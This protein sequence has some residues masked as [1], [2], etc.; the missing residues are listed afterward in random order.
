MI[1]TLGLAV[2]FFWM[3]REIKSCLFWTYL[4][5]LK[6]YHI[7]RFRAHFS[8]W[9]GRKLLTNP[10]SYLKLLILLCLLSLI[11]PS[12]YVLPF[13]GF[14]DAY[15]AY[16]LLALPLAF[17]IYVAEGLSAMISM[18]RKRMKGPKLTSKTAS[19]LT[20]IFIPLAAALIIFG[21]LFVDDLVYP[22]PWA[23]LDLLPFAFIIIVFDLLTPLLTSL[24]ILIL[25]PVTVLL[26][27]RM[28]RR[29]MK[30]REGLEKLLTIGV[31]GSYGKTSVK[32][33]LKTIL[34]KDFKVVST[35]KNHNSEVG[36]SE[37]IIKDVTED[38]EVFICE[39]GAYNR[40]A[41][42]L[43]CE[44]AKPK[45]GV[46]TGINNQHLATFGSQK[47][48]IRG[49]FE[50]IDALP[51]EG[52]AV[53]NW[54]N[55]FIRDNFNSKVNSLKYS[56]YNKE[57]IWTE[58]IKGDKEK[59][60][61]RAVT[62]TG[63][64]HPFEASLMGVHNVPNLLA[65]IAV[66]KKLGM[67]FPSIAERVKEIKPEQSGMKVLKSKDGYNVIDATYSS[68]SNGLS[69][70]LE[71]LKNWEGRKI[72]IMPC[73]IELGRDAKD[74]HY[75][76][77]RKIGEVCDMAV[78]TSRDYFKQIKKGALETGMKEENIVFMDDY[79]KIYNKIIYCIRD[80][81]VVFLE[82]R[83]PARLTDKLINND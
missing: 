72:L 73:L 2:L 54:D 53:L 6:N 9:N 34:S 52:L 42:R 23:I 21:R 45:I 71:Y 65:A 13:E 29:A 79:Q 20:V 15:G 25:Q 77:G 76:M 22:N 56:A 39:M 67:D 68:N 18:M 82:S 60:S 12:E 81:D 7:G 8:T 40:G 46:L 24:I 10:L 11:V 57:D 31:T 48:I 1:A 38:D 14:F 32:E 75:K 37:C 44:I 5:Q 49:K 27:G 17:L 63:E 80:T 19:L 62:K 83:V 26:R 51:D 70:H 66:A 4:W 36:I 50:L 35:D 64:S 3:F 58:D 16:L 33:F 47:N 55:E 74:A 59:I 78:I 61:F 41:I 30:K 69:S 43:A 28:I